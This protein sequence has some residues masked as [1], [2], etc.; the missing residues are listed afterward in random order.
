MMPTTFLTGP[1]GTGKTTYA[2]SR[3]Q[4]WLA[5]VPTR[6]ILVLVPQLTLAQPYRELL[7]DPNLPAAGQVDI[8]T[9]NGL[10]MKTIDLFW[11]L[12]SGT[13]RS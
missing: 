10:A 8:L 1:A 6:S 4:E 2:V 13:R 9:L 3:L 11:P 5:L 7:R 12:S